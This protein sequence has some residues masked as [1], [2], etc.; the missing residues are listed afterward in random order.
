MNMTEFQGESLLGGALSDLAVS[1]ADPALIVVAGERGVWRSLDAGTSWSGLNDNLPA[2]PVSRILDTPGEG[3]ELR[4]VTANQNEELVWRAGERLG[5]RPAPDS[6]R[7]LEAAEAARIATAVRARI[8]AVFRSS[9][10]IYAGTADGR[11]FVTTDGG[12]NWMPSA[13]LPDSGV[14]LRIV[15]DASDPTWAVAITSGTESSGRVLRTSNGGVFWEDITGGLAPGTLR[16]VSTDRATGAV[17]VATANGLYLNYSGTNP[18]A[19]F[20]QTLREDPVNDVALDR[21]GNQLYIALEGLGIYA[22]LAPHRFRDPRVLSI[23][24]RVLR[25]A[26]PGALLTVAGSRVQSAT[27]SGRAASI[28]AATDSETQ[29]QLPFELPE[30]SVRLELRSASGQIQLG[31]PVV[32]AVP[33]IF[34]DRDGNGIITDADTGLLIGSERPAHG[35]MRLQILA[36]GLGQVQPAWLAGVPAPLHNPPEVIA[37][38]TV[39]LD[40]EPVEATRKTLAP[41]YAGLYVVEIQLPALLNRGS[42]ELRLRVGGQES[43]RVYLVVEP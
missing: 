8:T 37:P 20:W 6:L 39:L 38:V 32:P 43:N 2:F 7:S 31:L 24:E 4:V 41:G 19:A 26:A 12:A 29:I 34:V 17:Y 25:A 10:L 18:T 27:A 13:V 23:G 16:G 33:S 40:G 30:S 14:V 1:P 35:G 22:T 15:A 9:N 42:A 5:W 28:L 36:T 11:I 21:N 3:T